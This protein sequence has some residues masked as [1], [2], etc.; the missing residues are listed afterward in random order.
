MAQLFKDLKSREKSAATTER[1]TDA[2]NVNG[3][4]FICHS[5]IKLLNENVIT[6]IGEFS[7]LV[8]KNSF[9]LLIHYLKV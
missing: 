9:I 2:L 4:V 6:F 1:I 3:W 7:E 5:H 8:K